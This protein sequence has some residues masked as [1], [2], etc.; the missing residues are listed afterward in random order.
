ML[1]LSLSDMWGVCGG[2]EARR[3]ARKRPYVLFRIV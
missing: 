3:F 2:D 1:Q